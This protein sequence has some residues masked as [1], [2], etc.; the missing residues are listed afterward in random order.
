MNLD[1][2]RRRLDE[3]MAH[4]LDELESHLRSQGMTPDEARVEARRRFGD[5]DQHS[6]DAPSTDDR[7]WRRRLDVLRQDL[8]HGLRLVRRHPLTT[9]L[10]VATL[11]VGVAAT[12]VVYSVVGAVVLAPLPFDE[13]DA[14]VHVSQTSPQ[15]RLYSTS[16][17]NFVDFRSRQRSF[18]EMA[19][20]GWE[21]PV[22]TGLGDPVSID[23]RRVSH[24]FFP[25]LGIPS[26]LGRNFLGEEDR[27]GGAN[28]V[29]LLSEGTWRRR[30]GA[31]PD[32][33]GRT[34]VLD[35]RARE[36]VG[37]VASDRAW[38]GVE[39]FVPLA[40]NPDVYR[41]DQRLET[42]A[43]LA[44]GV[45]LAD[46][47]RDMASIAAA[48]SL[49]YPESNDGWGAS[50][51]PA[52]EWLVGERLTRLGH[53][54]LGAVAL[55]LLMA[56]ASVSNLLLARASAR[57]R[58][59]GVRSALGAGRRR[60]A[61][62]LLAE[63]A[64]LATLGGPLALLLSEGGLRLAKAFGPGD[65]GRLSE[66]GLDGGA[67]AVAGGVIVGTV[68]LAGLAPAML[69]TRTDRHALLR[70]GA[71]S[72][73]GDGR[74][75]RDALVVAQ[76]ALAVTV[77]TGAGLLTR[78]FAEL[79]NVDLGFDASV[80]VRYAVRL[81]DARFDQR[82][83]AEYM[84]R[85]RQ[86][87]T[88]IRG[89]EAMGATTAPPFSPMRP[90]N[91]VARSDAEPDR[92]EDFQPVSWRAVTPGYFD[93]AGVRLVA[94]RTF[95]RDDMGKRGQQQP[96][97]PVV[98]DQ[99]LAA[100]LFPGEDPV[101]RRVTWFLPGGQQCVIIGV[102]ATTRDERLDVEPRPRIYRTFTFS[103]WDQPAVLVRTSGDPTALI[104]EL[105]AA[106]LR[107]DGSVPAMDPSVVSQ[108][109]RETIAWPRFSMQVLA[110][111]GLVA[112]LLA[113]MG[114]YGVT[115]FSVARRRQE[116]G[117]RIALGAEPGRL[118]WTVVART[119]RLAAAGTAL[120]VSAALLLGGFIGTLLHE[121]SRTDPV[122]FIVVPGLA[123]LV[124]VVSTWLPARRA[125]GLDPREALVD[126]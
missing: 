59:M 117:V 4:H 15:G 75:L 95:A 94:G 101:G 77:L 18:V 111:F 3:E 43:R 1:P 125:V 7:S 73:S 42:I 10:T 85:L 115:A 70:S 47:R 124:A 27:F 21:S 93:A 9:G 82:D 35:G 31:D 52:R 17:P 107:V 64:V 39:V 97:P 26:V 50:V 38:P 28:E 58:E 67:L 88:A 19:A 37:V 120:G 112:L 121:V 30:M 110:L 69:L 113:S 12:T 25:V 66:A 100:V 122:T 84:E 90:S 118:H 41:D 74:R 57:V 14:V 72:G 40:P 62:Q 34:L 80:V 46:A 76:F 109:A 119:L 16:E 53:L 55:F 105:R 87:L 68:A 104:P 29:V 106:T 86:E 96:N 6:D 44:P 5:P 8:A 108:D 11:A 13:P 32:V 102:V 89:V 45:S 56:C 103:D 54:L 98:I 78:S 126:D 71:R 91:F 2:H 63:G 92:Q 48:L 23:A 22:L 114:I 81:P 33:V 49:E 123:V 65:I 99:T 116:I 24:T 20:M 83:R 61:S 60:V 51:R 36:I 79:Q